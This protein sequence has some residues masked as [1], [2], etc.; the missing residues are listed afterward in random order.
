LHEGRVTQ[1]ADLLAFSNVNREKRSHLNNASIPLKYGAKK[2]TIPQP[3]IIGNPEFS[4]TPRRK[5]PGIAKLVISH[6]NLSCS[7]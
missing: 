1:V 3:P 5:P 7:Y 4:G 2:Q 6:T